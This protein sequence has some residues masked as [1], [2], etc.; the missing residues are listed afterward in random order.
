MLYSLLN[1]VFRNERMKKIMLIFG[2]R[3]E[4]IKMAPVIKALESYNVYFICGLQYILQK[5]VLSFHI[6]FLD[7]TIFYYGIHQALS[8]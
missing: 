8:A 6:D 3:P 1:F 7:D 4:A 2:T 5:S